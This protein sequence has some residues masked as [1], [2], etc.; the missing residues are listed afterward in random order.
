MCWALQPCPTHRQGTELQWCV[1]KKVG[2][3]FNFYVAQRGVMK[4][5]ASQPFA[6]HTNKL[7]AIL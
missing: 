1:L 2:H 7:N 5:T 3:A 6:V 4:Y